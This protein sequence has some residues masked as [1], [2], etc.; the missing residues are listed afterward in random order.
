MTAVDETPQLDEL[1]GD[2]LDVIERGLKPE[3]LRHTSGT[4]LY[5]VIEALAEAL[6]SDPGG[7]P[8]PPALDRPRVTGRPVRARRNLHRAVRRPARRAVRRNRGTSE[9]AVLAAVP[10]PLARPGCLGAR[11]RRLRDIGP[12]GYCPRCHALYRQATD[13]YELVAPDWDDVGS[14]TGPIQIRTLVLWECQELKD[15]RAQ[16]QASEVAA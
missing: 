11:C 14:E 5:P 3:P 9:P 2:L 10:A 15:R 4:D 1:F 12:S 6:A 7:D 13:L 8:D 16:P